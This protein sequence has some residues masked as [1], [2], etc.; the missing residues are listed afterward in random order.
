VF[1]IIKQEDKNML[2][3]TSL[4]KTCFIKTSLL[5]YQCH[6]AQNSRLNTIMSSA[7]SAKWVA[8]CLLTFILMTG[9]FLPNQFL[10][11]A[12]LNVNTVILSDRLV[13]ENDYELNFNSFP[14][15]HSLR[16]CTE[17]F[18]SSDFYLTFT[19][20]NSLWENP[21]SSSSLS[22]EESSVSYA[23]VEGGKREDNFVTFLI[24]G[25]TTSIS[26]GT[27][28][29]LGKNTD[30]VIPLFK[31]TP[32]GTRFQ[33]QVE[34]QLAANATEAIEP[35]L[36]AD[37]VIIRSETD[38]LT[39]TTIPENE[40]KTLI[41]IYQATNG[42]EWTDRAMNK[43][44][45]TN[46]PCIWTGISCDEG[47]V[48]R[49][50]REEKNLVGPLPNLSALSHLQ[51][52]DLG[53]NELTGSIPSDLNALTDLEE[54]NFGANQLT[55]MMPNLSDLTQLKKLK[56]GGGNQLSGPIPD[57]STLKNLIEL[58]LG[59][60][61]LTGDMPKLSSL[62]Q[63]EILNLSKNQ[64][65]G[66]LEAL[67]ALTQ[68]KVL[69]LSNNKLSGPIPDLSNLNELENLYLQNN[70][71]TGGLPSS[72]I[73]LNELMPSEGLDIHYNG[74]MT[75]D[76]TLLS[77]LNEKNPDWIETQTIP[78]TLIETKVLSSTEI[79]IF[80]EPI[81]YL[82]H[83]GYYQ[84]KYATESGG[85]YQ[86][87]R[88]TTL[89]KKANNEV[90]TDLSPDTTYY[91]TVETYTQA[92]GVQK[93][94]VTSFLSEEIS[95]HTLAERFPEIDVLDNNIMIIN[96]TS[97]DFGERFQ[98]S[99]VSK[100]IIVRN[101]GETEL[102]LSQP[103]VSG[104][105]FTLIKP[106]EVTTLRA[107]E[108]TS[109]SI[110]L[111][112]KT[113]GSFNGE[114]SLNNTDS[115]ENPFQFT[116]N[117]TI[118]RKTNDGNC[119][120][121][122]EIEESECESLVRFY[123]N[124]NGPNWIDSPNN[125]WND[126]RAPNAP[127]HWK[128]V[129]C[130]NGNVRGIERSQKNLEGTLPDLTALKRLNTL[131]LDNNQLTGP[132]PD[133]SPLVSL[134]TLNL[135]NNHLTGEI[136]NL[137]DLNNLREL[138]LGKNQ[139]SGI[140]PKSLSNLTALNTL[141]LD[142]NQLG[143]QIP[144]SLVQLTRLQDQAGLDL[145]YNK[146]MTGNSELIEFLN[147]KNPGWTTTQTIAPPIVMSPTVL[148][149]TEIQL[150][151]AS[152]PYQEDGGYYQIKYTTDSSDEVIVEKTAN[153][154][155]T[156]HIVKNLLP[157]MTYIFVLETYTPAHSAQQNA[158]TS[159]PSEE[160][161]A[162]TRQSLGPI[163]IS[164]PQPN[165]LLDMGESELGTPSTTTATLIVLNQ[166]DKPL[167]VSESVISGRQAND[168]RIKS[169]AAP[170]SLSESNAEQAITL[171]CIPSQM[172]VRTAILML[173]TN[174]P[175][176]SAVSYP[177]S[178][179]TREQE[180][181]KP[182][183]DSIPKPN[184][185]LIMGSDELGNPISSHL[186]LLEMGTAKLDVTASSLTGPHANDFKIVAGNAPFSIAD[187][188]PPHTVFLHCIPSQ[189]GQR[190][191]ELTLMTND[192]EQISVKYN[193][194]C[195]G[196]GP[197]YEAEPEAG[198]RLILQADDEN[199]S[200]AILN[201][202]NL[203]NR[204]LEVLK[205]EISGEDESDFSISAGAAPFSIGPQGQTH[206]LLITC[207]NEAPDERTATL[208]LTTNDKNHIAVTY[209]L[210]CFGKGEGPI[211]TSEPEAN[212]RLILGNARLENAITTAL[213]ISEAG[214]ETLVVSNSEISG[215]HQDEFSLLFGNEIVNE[216]QLF[217]IADGESGL[218]FTLKCTPREKGER[219]A[220]LTLTT[221]DPNQPTVSYPLTCLGESVGPLYA[222]EPEPNTPLTGAAI[223]NTSSTMTLIISEVG[224]EMLVVSEAVLSGSHQD[225]FSLL[226]ENENVS[227]NDE[228]S[229]PDGAPAQ[230]LMVRCTPTEIG[231]R[232]ATLSFNTN[233]PAQAQVSYPLICEGLVDEA[234]F[235]GEIQT[236]F[237]VI[238]DNLT[239]DSP[240]AI[241]L[242]GRIQPAQ[243]HIGQKANLFF[244]YHW[245][246]ENGGS[247]LSVPV[248][249][250]SQQ[251]LETDIEMT[252]FEGR[253][254]GL[255]GVFKIELGYQLLNE[256]L[257]FDEIVT[258]TVRPNNAPTDI[259]LDGN[260]VA[261]NSPS[262][263]QIGTFS[264]EDTDK[265]DW[266]VYGLIEN[267]NKSFK[268]VGNT[269][270]ISKKLDFEK[271]SEYPI[272]VRSVDSN[273][274]YQEKSFIIRI[275]ESAGQPIDIHL[276]QDSVLENTPGNMIVGR[277]WTEDTKQGD[278]DY[279]LLED[280][281]GYFMLD[282]IENNLLRLAADKQLDFETQSRYQITVRSQ[283]R[284]TGADIEK[285]FTIKLLNVADVIVEGEIRD[286]LT[287][288]LIERPLNAN[289]EIKFNVQL[290][291]DLT[292][293][294]QEADI[295]CM[296]LYLVN[297]ET[298]GIYVL[299]KEQ[300][301]AWDANM[302]TLPNVQRLTLQESHQL[303][304]WQ[305]ELTDL[306]QGQLNLYVGYTLV[307]TGELVY[308]KEAFRITFQE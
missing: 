271:A 215:P 76:A 98:D 94:N 302:S 292:H 32:S 155:T 147:A 205:S 56:L 127:C 222:S 117:G 284:E 141:H 44:N 18:I 63:L 202:S 245:T 104:S 169:G 182:A 266:F 258:L 300:W 282:P 269:L 47:H 152:I 59:N 239:I 9:F 306:N 114:V 10:Y 270:Q 273:G 121:Q 308:S 173:K 248:M 307:E 55:G 139:L 145:G 254:I 23:L 228:L 16:Y 165:T 105:D 237:D 247:S 112:S 34:T 278:Y 224:D 283:K 234:R 295:I 146:L 191:A 22:I 301:Q 305:G 241:K 110:R 233:D 149:E 143:G 95:A 75:N 28:F 246:P 157:N 297:D 187:N 232:T 279:E 43:W 11:A 199:T 91:F 74:L 287:N 87:N 253:L 164:T 166:G 70:Q 238:G 86:K 73:E 140:I 229:I 198:T 186:T 119:A 281:E 227:E 81:P 256:T 276:T 176:Q 264:T 231:E 96:G 78:P 154:K 249:I 38:C 17:T 172:G 60:N 107:G 14:T 85:P 8:N 158:L 162:T 66:T 207:L 103:I 195:E 189:I 260:T 53:K 58:S 92:H 183:Y 113:L 250:G 288:N 6:H 72:L 24:H 204:T 83:I 303:S 115:D 296:A 196:F 54:L 153:K 3:M 64:L 201:I 19:L 218:N 46:N 220:T 298:S 102:K 142:N 52:F 277:F 151:W 97:L 30:I 235:S 61:Q 88:T 299:E 69:D 159:A 99:E 116:L 15:D 160:V 286:I 111:E 29:V 108:S 216:N 48:T 267:P 7:L 223:V 82:E 132:I 179:Q 20:S 236:Q 79:Q 101:S 80:W 194:E 161:S 126:W 100:E 26:S 136:P 193:L 106:L 177:L 133:L 188:G 211:Y 1:F 175:N 181:R 42:P 274:S 12:S 185:T 130:R 123:E 226:I 294:G 137:I 27:C 206:T 125:Q 2:K 128:G 272:T 240:E 251:V 122:T 184:N 261:E 148:S 265:G 221:N 209:P 242:I 90:V 210:S 192:P 200:N 255:N 135:E 45:L 293:Y 129:T 190:T 174:D 214:D 197:I 289:E 213:L 68:L 13:A 4:F 212:R 225:D 89:N 77:F 257:F 41:D 57:L 263:T 275:T 252:L 21:L 304:I 65:T 33:I 171:E 37:W 170:F 168:F 217:S 62:T 259:L 134:E 39:V 36:S 178:C 167:E 150:R 35:S 208:T 291:P 262:N 5:H 138:K 244:R 51:I 49:L 268:I 203:G 25:N 290:I 131:I 180:T 71:L 230:S 50:A 67:T 93:N 285:D 84:V 124:T 280:A 120:T 163:Y 144:I 156:S 219:T 109:F 31:G 243:A 40:C 118:I